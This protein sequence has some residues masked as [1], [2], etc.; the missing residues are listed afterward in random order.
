MAS[1]GKSQITQKGSKTK[2]L[3]KKSERVAQQ[4]IYSRIQRNQMIQEKKMAETKIQKL[5]SFRLFLLLSPN[6]SASSQAGGWVGMG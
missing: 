5:V 3:K 1:K 4:I 6:F 2:R